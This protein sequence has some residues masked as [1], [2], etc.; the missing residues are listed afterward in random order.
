VGGA[1]QLLQAADLRPAAAA[2][3]FARR[4]PLGHGGASLGGD[5]LQLGQFGGVGFVLVGRQR[6]GRGLLGQP[7]A[8]L[9]QLPL[10][11]GQRRLGLPRLG[12]Q[13]AD[14]GAAAG[15]LGPLPLEGGAKLGQGQAVAL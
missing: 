12:L 1:A 8:Q 2:L 5:G 7:L 15:D 14:G 4:L 10:G 3:T 11:L 6:V 13:P 9:G